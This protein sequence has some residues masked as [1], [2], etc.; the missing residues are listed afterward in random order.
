MILSSCCLKPPPP[1]NP[2]DVIVVEKSEIVEQSDGSYLV[3]KAWMLK[4]LE[5]EKKLGAA[6]KKCLEAK[7]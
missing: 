2:D 5:M 3:N 1:N 4:R 6:L 7:R